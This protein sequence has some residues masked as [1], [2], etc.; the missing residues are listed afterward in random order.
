MDIQKINCMTLQEQANKIEEIYNEAI[1]KL[2]ALSKERQGLVKD[3]Q[4]IIW[5]YIDELEKQ[6]TDAI[7]TSLN[8]PPTNQ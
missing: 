7:R 6:K 4:N 8:L 2:D 1:Q 5:G 3:R